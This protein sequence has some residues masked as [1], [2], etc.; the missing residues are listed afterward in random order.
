MSFFVALLSFQAFGFVN[1]GVA[2]VHELVSELVAYFAGCVAVHS[3]HASAELCKEECHFGH[4]VV[5]H[6]G[7]NFPTHGLQLFFGESCISR[8]VEV[9]VS[10]ELCADEHSDRW[11]TEQGCSL[12]ERGVF[13]CPCQNGVSE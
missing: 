1:A 12:V 11:R 10:S 2:V 7:E 5:A 13:F 4:G 3:P 8:G 9:E 6:N